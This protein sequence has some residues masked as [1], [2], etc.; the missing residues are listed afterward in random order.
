MMKKLLLTFAILLGLASASEAILFSSSPISLSTENYPTSVYAA[1]TN[2]PPTSPN[3]IAS[4]TWLLTPQQTGVCGGCGLTVAGQMAALGFNVLIGP[5][6][7]SWPEGT[8]SDSGELTAIKNAGIY[9][10]AG[11]TVPY[12]TNTGNLSVSNILATCATYAACSNIIGYGLGDETD[13]AGDGSLPQ[14]SWNQT[15]GAVANIT[16]YDSTRPSYINQTFWVAQPY[17]A[18]TST[19]NFGGSFTASIS[20]TTMTVTALSSPSGVNVTAPIS[21]L[22]VQPG[23]LVT[24]Q[25]TGT[26]GSTGTY[27]VTPSQSAA[28]NTV[29]SL[30]L[31]YYQLQSLGLSGLDYYALTNTNLIHYDWV[32]GT[33]PHYYRTWAGGKSDFLSKHNDTLWVEGLMTRALR[34]SMKPGQPLWMFTEPGGDNLASGGGNTLPVNTTNSSTTIVNNSG[35]SSFTATW[36]GLTVNG[37]CLPSNP[38]ISSIT[39]ATH[40]VI[41]AA[42]TSTTTN[43]TVTVS[44]GLG[45]TGTTGDCVAGTANLCV[46]NGNEYRPTG[47]EVY[48]ETWMHFIDGANGNA[49]FCQDFK[50]FEFCLGDSANGGAAATAAATNMAYVNGVTN[51]YAAVLNSSGVG[52]CSMDSVAISPPPGTGLITTTTS[53]SGGILTISTGTSTVPGHAMVKHNSQSNKWYLVAQTLAYGSAT[54]TFTLSGLAGKTATIVQDAHNHYGFGSDDTGSTF[55]INGSSQFS[56]TFGSGGDDYQTKI[57][58]IQ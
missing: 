28:S 20:G 57:Y 12:A 35:F 17:F 24:A 5:G 33:I 38:T 44:G 16:S 32:N 27:T 42:A 3:W 26:A 55:T 8:A 21:G 2:G 50:T 36:V 37:S 47:A 31:A 25:L 52:D 22:N 53:C 56:D 6:F 43:C 23:T 39:D 19:C 46:V 58:L 15:A 48:A 11:M 14:P 49:Y 29:T 41:S 7:N 1:W 13:C 45:N 54:L 4:T 40:A 10:I 9:T 34:A 51:T 18:S 30:G